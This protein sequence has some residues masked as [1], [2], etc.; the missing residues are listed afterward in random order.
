MISIEILGLRGYHE[1]ELLKA[2]LI[3]ALEHFEVE[4]QIA[5]VTDVD[6]LVNTHVDGIPALVVNGEVLVENEIPEVHDL[7]V[8]LEHI[9][10]KEKSSTMKKIITSTDFS[11]TSME[12]FRFAVKLASVLGTSV[13]LVHVY[14]GTF[15]PDQPI[16]MQTAPSQHEAVVRHLNNFQKKG[17]GF[18]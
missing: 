3:K 16:I 10:K 5:E 1:T 9:V 7:E 8:M 15:S 12:G 11:N 2:N 4:T 14:S 6:A 17:L 13:E 18:I